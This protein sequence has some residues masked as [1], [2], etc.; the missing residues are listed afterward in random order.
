MHFQLSLKR[1]WTA[2]VM[3]AVIVPFTFVLTW[4]GMEIY[5]KSLAEALL[6]AS[7]TNELLGAQIEAE[8]NRFKTLL[9][10]KSDPL[11]KLI[12]TAEP[13]KNVLDMNRYLTV[14]L[15]REPLISHVSIISASGKYITSANPFN[16]ENGNKITSY[17]EIVSVIQGQIFLGTNS[18]P[19]LAIPLADRVYIGTSRTHKDA[20][21]LIVSVPIGKPAKGVLL[22]L[23]RVDEIWLN[24]MQ[25]NSLN[26]PNQSYNYILDRRGVLLTRLGQSQ[27]QSG[28]IMTSFPIVRAAL[29]QRNWPPHDSFRGVMNTLVYGSITP[30]PLLG[31]SLVSEVPIAQIIEP[32]RKAIIYILMMTLFSLSFFIWVVLFLIK[33]T[34]APIQHTIES[35]QRVSEGDY[36][37]KPKHSNIIEL[38]TL[39]NSFKIMVASREYA[40]QEVKNSEAKFRGIIESSMDGVLLVNEQGIIELVNHSL[41]SLSGYS[42]QELVG[43]PIG[44][45]VPAR[46]KQHEQLRKHY[47]TQP[48]TR[49]MGLISDLVLLRKNGTEVS[50]EISLNPANMQ[51]TKIVAAMVKD[52]SARKAAETKILHQAHYDF[53]TGLANRFLSL[54]RLSHLLPQAKRNNTLIAILFID[55]D[56]FK[57]VND[58]LGHES[59]DKLLIE[60]AKRLLGAVRDCDTVGRLGGDE[61]IVL[62]S[63]IDNI[64]TAQSIV[65]TLLSRIRDPYIIDG[66]ELMMTSSLGISIYPND[67]VEVSELLRHADSAM[68]HAK[69]I[70]RNSY[71]YYTADM[72]Q[73]VARRLAIEEQLHGALA[74]GEFQV[75]YQPKIDLS[76]G[77]IMGAEALLRWKNPAL[78]QVTPDEFIPIAEITGL[79]LEIGEYVLTEAM[80]ATEKWQTIVGEQ[81]HIAI[82]ISP[83]QF[84]EAELVPFIDKTMKTFNIPAQGLELEITEG[85]LV[86]G[87][88]NI[89]DALAAIHTLGIGIA[90]DDFG[91]GYSSLSH[92]RKYPFTV[93]KIDR[94]FINDI[95]VD[96]S[97]KE[98]TNAAIAMSHALNMKV[99]AEGIETEEQLIA[100]KQMKCDFGQGDFIGKPMPEDDLTQIL[101]ATAN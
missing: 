2:L 99:V 89:D 22:A 27:F 74:R 61:F 29:I 93:L 84:R 1:A 16:E 21:T 49:P 67:G 51:N 101:E 45:L 8:L 97:D 43:Q 86:S 28:D 9:E 98:L 57:K 72:N 62:L 41:I 10:N 52:V 85:V 50:V 63:E 77:G 33:K 44:M 96:P 4:Y 23:I 25:S 46:F 34:I 11:V 70:G 81:F 48:T 73:L 17:Q 3:F 90:M 53:L 30:I 69:S 64:A 47:M 83:R 60:S 95:M 35:C 87:H 20:V 76:T 7:H 75:H 6:K 42:A 92:L 59:G 80:K 39:T 56:D 37:Y 12:D 40:E 79:I 38:N 100:L 54:D 18:A 26:E 24:K 5:Q 58:T 32:A 55:L 66:R 88:H 36:Q 13:A 82:N 14:I 31:W 78:G 68:Y 19:E 65:D 91:T 94:S 71:S 15:E